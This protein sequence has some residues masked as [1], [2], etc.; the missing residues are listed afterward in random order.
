MNSSEYWIYSEE[1]AGQAIL[2][3]CQG[4]VYLVLV[5]TL[6]ESL[7]LLPLLIGSVNVDSVVIQH[8]QTSNVPA[9]KHVPGTSCKTVSRVEG[10]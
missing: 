7:L 1:N 3:K 4:T 5:T 2:A 8:V 10:Y 6:F 9:E